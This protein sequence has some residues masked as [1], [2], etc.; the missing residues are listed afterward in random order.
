MQKVNIYLETSIRG[1]NRT[2]GW[3]GYLVEYIDGR[4]KAHTREAYG[5][6]MGVT[7]NMLILKVFCA[8]LD[9]MTRSCAITVYTDSTYL[10][11]GCERRLERWKENGWKTAHNEEIKNRALWQQISEKISAHEVAFAAEY[12]HAHKNRMAAEL[13]N[14]RMGNV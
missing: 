5:Y 2:V 3:Y 1:L 12:H 10:R 9:R 14:R 4:G 11:E 6:E 8:A 13:I 7:P